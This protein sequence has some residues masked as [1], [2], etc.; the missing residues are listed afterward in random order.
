MQS[1]QIAALL[2]VAIADTCISATRTASSVSLADVQSCVDLSSN[3]D[4]VNIPAGSA[5]W[6]NGLVVSGKGI[7]IIGTGAASTIISNAWSTAYNYE[8]FVYVNAGPSAFTRLSGFAIYAIDNNVAS[9]ICIGTTTTTNYFRVDNVTLSSVAHAGLMIQGWAVGVI[10]NCTI[11]QKVNT[12]ATGISIVGEGEHSWDT[13]PPSWGDTNKVYIEDCVF[14]WSGNGNGA[15]DAYNGA[16][17]CFRNNSI[18]NVNVGNHGTDS[19]GA[20]RSCHSFEVYGNRFTETSGSTTLFLSFRG[21]TGLIFSNTITGNHVYSFAM[22]QNYRT[23]G[24]NIYEGLTPCCDPWGPVNGSNQYD[25]NADQ[26]G[27]PAYDSIGRTSPTEYH[28]G[29]ALNGSTNGYTVQASYP[30]YL[31]SNSVNGAPL[32]V[33]VG[34]SYNNTGDYAR[35]PPA[36]EI[37]KENRDYYVDVV[38]TGYTPLSYPHPL[39]LLAG[40]DATPHTNNWIWVR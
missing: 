37:I 1:L 19:S 35:I 16:R 22:L 34:N 13:R 8:H 11:N 18:T 20:N 26:Y 33:T 3:G 21:G 23:T 38:K 36:T 6:T 14:Q 5:V 9:Q 25:G 15:V 4:T 31:W 7:N 10:D 27:W 40:V 29:T 28:T 30:L 32:T 17:F 24:T 39:V 12:S 2:V